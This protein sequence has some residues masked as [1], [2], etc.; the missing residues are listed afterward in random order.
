MSHLSDIIIVGAGASGLMAGISAAC[1][2]A[3]VVILEHMDRPGKK[4]LLTGN[5]KCNYTNQAQGVSYYRGSDPAFVLPVFSQFGFDQMVDFLQRLGIHPRIKRDGY[6]YPASEQ[7]AAMLEVLLLEARRLGVVIECNVGIRSIQ[8]KKEKFYFE[9]KQGSYTSK[10]CILA[11]G[12]KSYKRTGSD[13]SGIPYIRHFSHHIADLVPALVSLKAKEACCQE[14]K[15]LRVQGRAAAYVAGQLIAE[16]TGELQFTEDGISG[17]PVFQISRYIAK[18]LHENKSCYVVLD[19]MPEYS[20]EQLA[21]L[22]KHRFYQYGKHK[23]V[24]Q[25]MLGLFHSRLIPLLMKLSGISP[26]AVAGSCGSAQIKA[27]VNGIKNFKIDVPATRSFDFAQVTAG[28]VLTAEINHK[29]LESKLVKNLFFAGE[30]IDIDGMCG[31][32][33]LQWAFCSG[34]VAGEHAGRAN[35]QKTAPQGEN[36]DTNKTD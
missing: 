8:R 20:P 31:G 19:F 27:L 36:Y 17:I 7:A 29:T 13:G 18:A 21:V 22:L 26:E 4:L 28:G 33:N 9:T 6:F 1:Q 30:V 32:Y 5:G 12:G 14:W 25:A 2:N 15:A 24:Y 35:A 34:Y 10:S 16:D 23:N 3:R 11:T